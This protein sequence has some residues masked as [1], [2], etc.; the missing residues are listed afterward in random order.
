VGGDRPRV[1]LV[2]PAVGIL[3]RIA[4]GTVLAD[5]RDA[6]ARTVRVLPDRV[7]AAVA[8]FAPR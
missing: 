6:V 4:S 8:V 7:P 1:F 5:H 3:A 2:Y